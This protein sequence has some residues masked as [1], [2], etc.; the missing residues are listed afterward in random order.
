MRRIRAAIGAFYTKAYEEGITGMAAMVAFNL[1]LAVFPFALLILFI[2]GRLTRDATVEASL[3]ADLE[4]LFPRTARDTLV[5]TVDRVQES[6]AS[7][8]IVGALGS[9]WVGLSFWGSLDTAFCR[10]YQMRC[11][12]WVR[13]KLFGLKM[14]AVVVLF[15]AATVGVPTLATVLS[16]GFG[17]FNAVTLGIGL[18]ALFG[19][20]CIIYRSVPNCPV[21]WQAVWPGALGATLAM[22]VVDAAFPVYISSV[23]TVGSL[24]PSLV[25]ALI[26]MLWFYALSLIILGGAVVN[27]LRLERGRRSDVEHSTEELRIVQEQR[28][29]DER[30][31]A[32]GAD[33]PSAEATHE[34]RADKA[35][36]LKEKLEEAKRAEQ[37]ALG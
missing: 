10:I 36:Y 8:G 15:I 16:E 6:S 24:G 5:D 1:M 4:Q 35:A 25:F 31:R 34:R 23:S 12:S 14:M 19:A 21:P 2:G 37:R 30:E 9:I 33:E 22:A 28:E 26:A 32:A 18:V 3:L 27:E 20:L 13:Q 17:G 11:R 7:L 29:R